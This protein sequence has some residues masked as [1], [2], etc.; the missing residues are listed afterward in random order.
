MPKSLVPFSCP[1]GRNLS[2]KT[3]SG[4]LVHTRL[5]LGHMGSILFHIAALGSRKELLEAE[6]GCL[7][8]A[9]NTLMSQVCTHLIPN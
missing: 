5:S 2:V 1:I 3:G 8:F 7:N 6:T 9:I 4:Y